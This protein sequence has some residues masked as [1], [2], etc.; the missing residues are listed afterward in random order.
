VVSLPNKQKIIED[1]YKS[2]ILLPEAKHIIFGNVLDF[3]I[4]LNRS[5]DNKVCIETG[6]RAGYLGFDS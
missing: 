2:R 1:K 5:R 6:L 4:P 3:S